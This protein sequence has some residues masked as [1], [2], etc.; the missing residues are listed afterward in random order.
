MGKVLGGDGG[1]TTLSSAAHSFCACSAL[2]NSALTLSNSSFLLCDAAKSACILSC[3]ILDA[4]TLS[5]SVRIISSPCAIVTAPSSADG[6]GEACLVLLIF[7]AKNLKNKQKLTAKCGWDHKFTRPPRWA[8]NDLARDERR[9]I[10]HVKLYLP[11]P[12]PQQVQERSRNS[13][14][15]PSKPAKHTKRR[16]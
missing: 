1:D 8:P 9:R 6:A 3:S 11:P 4:A 5:C 2:R 14:R 16:L 7:S 15:T 10:R 13:T 12:Q